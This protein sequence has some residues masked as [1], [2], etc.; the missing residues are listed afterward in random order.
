MERANHKLLAG[1]GQNPENAVAV[2]S[3][4]EYSRVKS[5]RHLG[6]MTAQMTRDFHAKRKETGV[7]SLLHRRVMSRE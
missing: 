6:A 5:D 7:G 2:L 1:T 3:P 4:L